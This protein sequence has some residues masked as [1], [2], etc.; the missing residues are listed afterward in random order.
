M[1]ATL[2]GA[3]SAV[4]SGET[5]CSDPRLELW[6]R[7]GSFDHF[8]DLRRKSKGRNRGR[9][10]AEGHHDSLSALDSRYS[11][12]SLGRPLMASALAVIRTAVAWHDPETQELRELIFELS[13]K[14]PAVPADRDV[15]GHKP[16]PD[17]AQ[18]P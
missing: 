8:L 15:P 18:S 12:W 1:L 9:D 16:V 7:K 6:P 3:F 14:A 5:P 17:L 11:K 13:C 2:F 4:A 10:I